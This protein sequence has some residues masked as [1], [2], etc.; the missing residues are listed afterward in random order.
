MLYP[1][2]AAL[3]SV[4]FVLFIAGIITY[5]FLADIARFIGNVR[6]QISHDRKE[7]IQE[8]HRGMEEEGED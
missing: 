8:Y 6:K 1:Y 7:V 2:A 5:I 4:V 3:G